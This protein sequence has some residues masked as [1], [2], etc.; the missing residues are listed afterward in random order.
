MWDSF[1]FINIVSFESKGLVALQWSN[2]LDNRRRYRQKNSKNIATL[3]VH[4]AEQYPN[5]LKKQYFPWKEERR[6]IGLTTNKIEKC[7]NRIFLSCSF[8][9]QHTQF[10]NGDRVTLQKWALAFLP[11]ILIYITFGKSIH[12]ITLFSTFIESANYRWLLWNPH[13]RFWGKAWIYWKMT[14][15]VFRGKSYPIGCHA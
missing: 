3:N 12:N 6:S 8:R 11:L 9:P 5:T 13:H 14:D 4:K 15:G 10:L 2:I 7:A 1:R